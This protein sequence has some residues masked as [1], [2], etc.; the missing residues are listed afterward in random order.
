MKNTN[1]IT[2]KN[3]ILKS[4]CICVPSGMCHSHALRGCPHNHYYDDKNRWICGENPL[5]KN[6][7][8]NT[9]NLCGEYI[10][11]KK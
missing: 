3:D 9:L 1:K 10:I 5:Y 7:Y 8:K 4:K 2:E 6:N 11:K